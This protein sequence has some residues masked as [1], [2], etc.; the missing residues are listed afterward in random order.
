MCGDQIVGDFVFQAKGSGFFYLYAVESQW[1]FTKREMTHCILCFRKETLVE[2][3]MSMGMTR[4]PLREPERHSWDR[5]NRIWWLTAWGIEKGWKQTQATHIDSHQELGVIDLPWHEQSN[6]EHSAAWEIRSEA[7]RRR[8][9]GQHYADFLQI[10][11][12]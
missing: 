2:V 10:C 7:N 5:V 6:P 12:K 11:W 8:V 9:M 4:G 3:W 1:L